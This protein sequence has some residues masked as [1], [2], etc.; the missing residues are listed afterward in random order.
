MILK[1]LLTR[2]SVK[3]KTKS[4]NKFISLVLLFFLVPM[5]LITPNAQAKFINKLKDGFYFEKYK[6]EDEART[7]LLQ[8]HPIGSDVDGLIK[9]L[10]EAGAE[11]K[12]RDPSSFSRF[13]EYDIWWEQGT[14]GIY[15]YRYNNKNLINPVKWGGGI[16]IDKNNR[17]IN[18]GVGREYMGL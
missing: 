6:T 4:V 2:I 12:K 13:K 10:K 16:R 3:K 17:I 15:S 1:Q 9:T 14:V 5:M 18:F 11:I 8:L 7:A